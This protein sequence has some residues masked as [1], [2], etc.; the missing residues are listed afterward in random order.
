MCYF[1]SM[2]WTDVV[3]AAA[4]G[5]AGAAIPGWL[6]YLGLRRDRSRQL[7]DRWRDDD[8]PV[9]A[10]ARGL[11]QDIDPDHRAINVSSAPG[12]EQQTWNDILGR[13]ATVVRQLL[14]M[15][16]GHP[17]ASIRSCAQELQ[18]QVAAATDQTLWL[19]KDMLG[20]RDSQ[21]QHSYARTCH[22]AATATADRLQDLVTAFGS[23]SKPK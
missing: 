5:L 12:I 18:V 15:A 23:G 3:S 22:Q 13:R 20:N 1:R 16:A 11:L 21:D 4:G 8:A 7:E 17:S 19:V 9:M 10:D 6:G 14:A 2:S